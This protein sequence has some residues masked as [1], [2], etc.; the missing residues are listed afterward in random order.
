MTKFEIPPF[1]IGTTSWSFLGYFYAER[2]PI[3][4][5]TSN[6][7]ASDNPWIALAAVLEHAKRGV[8]DYIHYRRNGLIQAKKRGLIALVFI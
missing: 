3:D 5:L 2:P 1:L 6:A 4:L 8:F 7:L